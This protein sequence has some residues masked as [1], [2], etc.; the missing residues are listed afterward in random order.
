MT[1][2]EACEYIQS[3]L[4][5]YYNA[6]KVNAQLKQF[7]TQGMSYDD[8]C[9]RVMYWYD[10][11]GK[12][13]PSKSNGGIAIISFIEVAFQQWKKS[14][15][16]LE[17]KKKSLDDF[18]LDTNKSSKIISVKMDKDFKLPNST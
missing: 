7:R 11:S 12:G 3:K 5:F 10:H 9:E 18:K 14:Q 15:Q 13:D 2:V 8:I 4:G 17:Q 16:Q 1:F 6:K